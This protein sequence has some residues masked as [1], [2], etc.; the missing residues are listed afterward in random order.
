M[1]KYIEK[2]GEKPFRTDQLWTWIYN[3]G[4]L[5]FKSMTNLSRD[6]RSKLEKIAI[7]PPLKLIDKQESNLSGTI[8]FL[9]ELT[10]GQHIE[11]VYI[12]EKSRRT[13]CLSS[14]V[15]CALD[16]QFCAT[17]KMGFIRNLDC[18]EICGQI[19]TITRETGQKPTNIV[20][21]GMGEPFL[22]YQNVIKALF[23]INDPEGIAIGN[24]KITISTAGIVPKL[25]EYA[26]QGLPFKLAIS[27]NATTN[28][29]RTKLMPINSK[30][31]LQDLIKAAKY[32]TKKQK[33]RITFEYVL[34]KGVNDSPEDALRLM[35]L[36]RGVPCKVNLIAYNSTRNQYMRPDEEKI[37][38]FAE[39]IRTLRAP[40]T[41][42]ISHGQ[43][44]DGACGQLATRKIV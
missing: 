27:L 25:Y 13:V 31:P 5:D 38:A 7:I 22:N 33:K 32:Y 37:N 8:K 42:R 41:V 18:H 28:R 44:I 12:P 24:R 39:S 15:G 1:R 30:Y 29:Q 2:I 4:V 36:V 40:V 26:D 6:F 14:Q 35:T 11:S 20:I 43:D 23:I 19:L 21:M 10:D 3:K 17:G 9:W 34:I 16:C